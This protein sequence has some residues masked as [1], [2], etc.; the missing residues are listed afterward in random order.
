M[1]VWVDEKSC[2][3]IDW[4]LDGVTSKML[5]WWWCNM[6]KG[7]VLWHPKEHKEFYWIK[8]PKH[9]NAI[10]AIHM[11]PQV[12]SDGTL[13]K[14]CIKWEDVENLPEEI[15]SLIVFDHAVIAAAISI[16]GEDIREDA[17]PLGYRIHQWEATDFGVRGRSTAIP[18]KA[19]P[20]ERLLNIWAPHCQEEINNFQE[21]LP[22]L[23]RLWNVVKDP[24]INPYFSFEV[25]K[26]GGKIRY[27][28]KQR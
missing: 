12:W 2:V 9:G 7:F 18:T 25:V 13:I 3:H 10:G 28:Y 16:T 6:E 5:N 19:E 15:Q 22:Q 17:P 8:R 1:K 4:E 11:A 26:E 21:F 23:Y 14:P 20:K 27:K 24:E